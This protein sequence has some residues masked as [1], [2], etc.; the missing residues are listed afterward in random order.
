VRLSSHGTKKRIFDWIEVHNLYVPSVLAIVGGFLII[1]TAWLPLVLRKL[2]L[3]LPIVAVAAGYGFALLF[4]PSTL[5]SHD[6]DL[7]DL[8]H[9]S[10]IIIIV[11]LMGAGL[12]IERPFSWR[13]WQT[14][15]RLL[16]IAMPLTIAMITLVGYVVLALP[17]SAALLL[18]AT[19]APTDPVLAADVQENPP[20][21]PDGGEVRFHLT[22][23]AGLND[24]LAFPFVLLAIE[25]VSRQWTSVWSAWLLDDVLW[26]LACGAAVGFVS[27]RLFGWLTFKIPRLKL[28]RTG[29]GLVALGVAFIC[30]GAAQL[31]QG[32]GFL[33]VF[34]SAVTLRSTDRTSDFHGAMAE[35][36]EQVE[37]V[38]M[39]A[40][41]MIFGAG[42]GTDLLRPLTGIDIVAAVMILLLLR[43]ASAGISL[44]GDPIPPAARW[45]IA[46]FGIRGLGTFYYLAFAMSRAQFPDAPRIA[47]IACLVVLMSI[48]LHGIA[49]TPLMD[50]VDQ[51]RE[52]TRRRQARSPAKRVGGHA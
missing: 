38:L 36:S 30:Y 40:V 15:W 32:N 49:S 10:E 28:S 1:L 21:E 31:L 23:E 25:L 24:G 48:I 41:L 45:I 29:D 13:K 50:W 33:A 2:P 27:G 43:T 37:R 9:V 44:I 17:F 14:V 34:I 4:P 26:A 46:F 11:A 42:L 51:R 5:R 3:S 12:R 16:A 47:A 7:A 6:F 18:G 39:V 22:A 52:A 35:F 20:N 19:L 8:E